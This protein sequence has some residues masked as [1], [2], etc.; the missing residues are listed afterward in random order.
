MAL[1]PDVPVAKDSQS[2]NGRNTIVPKG[3][4]FFVLKATVII[5]PKEKC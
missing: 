1:A 4:N 2:D 5:A 3:N